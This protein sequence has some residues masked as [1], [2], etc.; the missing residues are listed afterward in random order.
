LTEQMIL[1]IV[2]KLQ[3]ETVTPAGGTAN[4]KENGLLF[5]N[6]LI[7]A[8][9]K[10]ELE[11]WGR[12]FREGSACSIFNHAALPL[13]QRKSASTCE[14]CIHF[15]VVLT[16]YDALKSPDVTVPVDP[17]GCVIH[18]KLAVHDGWYASASQATKSGTQTR[19][20]QLSML[21]RV[22][23]LRVIF[24]DVLNRK[25]YLAK[26]DTARVQA[27]CA[28]NSGT[29]FAF[30]VS[31]EKD[32]SSGVDALWKT[33][34]TVCQS[35]CSVLRLENEGSDEECVRSIVVDFQDKSTRLG[36]AK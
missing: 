14:M 13:S 9:S 8:R 1:D 5:G 28:L 26:A 25:C 23:W 18:D 3:L 27:A 22:K 19:K 2:L 10:E 7:V 32:A 15:D 17:S 34:R 11:V 24:L 33:D 30:F 20:K 35:L 21:H 12:S 16:T 6:T 36:M 4:R 31:D 29:R